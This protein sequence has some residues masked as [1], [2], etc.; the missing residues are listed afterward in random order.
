MKIRL[1]TL[2]ENSNTTLQIKFSIYICA[3]K[4]LAAILSLFF[5][6]LSVLPCGDE[7]PG[8]SGEL[9]QVANNGCDRPEARDLC[10]P[11]CHC[12]C[13][14]TQFT[15]FRFFS[16]QAL[17]PEIPIAS[18]AHFDKKEQEVLRTFLQP[19]RV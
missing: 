12:Q 19:P 9:E 14:S 11:F 18:F 2:Q 15:D 3:V 7:A 16:F 8:D 17:Q 5:F 4:I 10:S 13:C 6:T 1:A